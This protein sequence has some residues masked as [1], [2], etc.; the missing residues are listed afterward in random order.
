[1]DGI[2][3]N[4]TQEPGTLSDLISALGGTADPNTNDG[5]ENKET[6]PAGNDGTTDNTDG[7]ANEEN[8]DEGTGDESNQDPKNNQQNNNA[9]RQ[10]ENA[11]KANETFA[12]LRV[13]NAQ[14]EKTLKGVAAVLGIDLKNTSTEDIVKILQDKVTNAQAKQQGVPTELLKRLDILEQEKADRDLKDIRTQA[15]LGFQK[16]KDRFGLDDKGLQDFAVELELEGKNPFTTPMDLEAAY[17]NKHLDD[18]LLAAKEQGIKE[19]QARAS[20]A[21]NSSTPNNKQGGAGNTGDD[22]TVSTVAELNAWFNN[23]KK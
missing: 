22:E 7:E 14:Y 6:N 1:M 18:I 23:H 21:S 9:A 5:E 2:D 15:F 12:K 10:Q 20:K 13:T 16:V 8:K 11:R 17:I 19:E 4:T 3:E